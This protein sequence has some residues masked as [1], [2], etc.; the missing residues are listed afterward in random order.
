MK[1]LFFAAVMLAT[2]DADTGLASGVNNAL[3]RVAGLFAVAALGSVAGIVFAGVLGPALPGVEF[4]AMAET[5]SDPAIESLRIAAT[6]RAFQAI[7]AISAVMC[8]LAAAIAWTTQ[9]AWSA[10]DKLAA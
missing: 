2:P 7:A 5:V 9:P 8:L 4:G 6:N 1:R 3:A 10:S